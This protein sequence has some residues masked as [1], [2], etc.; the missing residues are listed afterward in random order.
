MYVIVNGLP[1]IVWKPNADPA[2][3][4]EPELKGAPVNCFIK[5]AAT[6]P[7][8]IGAFNGSYF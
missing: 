7:L 1:E 6:F 4:S 8:P 3:T 5:D 2:N